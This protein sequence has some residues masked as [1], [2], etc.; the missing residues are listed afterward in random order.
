MGRGTGKAHLAFGSLPVQH[1]L[2]TRIKHIQTVT[3][4]A[5]QYYTLK[6]K[7][8]RSPSVLPFLHL[9]TVT[10]IISLDTV[11]VAVTALTQLQLQH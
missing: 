10:L 7:A 6:L 9:P 8:R 3:D 4:R 5:V 2:S 11:A 1:R